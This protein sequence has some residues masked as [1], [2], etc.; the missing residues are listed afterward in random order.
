[1]AKNTLDKFLDPLINKLDM[2]GSVN[3]TPTNI[4]FFDNVG[5]QFFWTGANPLGSIGVQVSIDYDPRFPSAAHWTSL[6]SSPGVP[7][8]LS[9]AGVAGSGYMDL[10]QLSATWIRPIYTTQ[11][12]SAGSLTSYLAC[13][14]LQ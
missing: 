10:N 9:P 4:E 8:V 1:M 7:L 11:V 5:Y 6:E 13:K 12:S 2:S 3:G 14:G